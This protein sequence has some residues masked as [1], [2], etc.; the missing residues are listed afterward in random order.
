ML[1]LLDPLT[2]SNVMYVMKLR[3]SACNY[4]RI[5]KVQFVLIINC[6]PNQFNEYFKNYKLYMPHH[7]GYGASLY[8]R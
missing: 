3:T 4:E 1:S 7:R 5:L 6:N 2:D 8:S